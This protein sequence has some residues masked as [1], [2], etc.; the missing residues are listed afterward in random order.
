MTNATSLSALQAE[1]DAHGLQ[2]GLLFLNARV[3]HRYTAVYRF[4]D[5]YLRRLGFID[6]EGGSGAAFANVPFKDSFCEVAVREGRLVVS[7]MAGDAR[8]RDRPNPFMLGSYVGLPLSRG[9]GALYGT[10]C[11][12]D[13]CSHPLSD[14]E[15]VFLEQASHLLTHFCLRPGMP[16]HSLANALSSL[17]PPGALQPRLIR[18]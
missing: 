1:L 6:K 10:L 18:S 4:R 8:V 17:K 14:T 12:Y 16:L 11:H 7:D 9:P 13:I 3:P 2:A 15:L 5:E